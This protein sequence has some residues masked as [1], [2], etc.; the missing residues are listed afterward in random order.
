MGFRKTLTFL[1]L[2]AGLVFALSRWAQLKTIMRDQLRGSVR[3][4]LADA[5]GAKLIE[6]GSIDLAATDDF[7]QNLKAGGASEAFLK[8]LRATQQPE[9]TTA[10]KPIH[11]V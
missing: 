11:Q 6:L 5:S 4:G 2:A 7:R 8:A 1:M 10:R 9:P 3:A